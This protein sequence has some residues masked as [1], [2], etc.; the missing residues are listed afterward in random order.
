M[1][2]NNFPEPVR[3][4]Y[5]DYCKAA[6]ETRTGHLTSDKVERRRHARQAF[7]EACRANHIEVSEVETA[8]TEGQR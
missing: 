3:A 7:I 8:Y 4:T 1:T 6:K 5:S 2:Y